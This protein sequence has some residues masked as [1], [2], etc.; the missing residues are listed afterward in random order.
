MSDNKLVKTIMDAALF[1]VVFFA[2]ERLLK[3]AHDENKM[4]KKMLSQLKDCEKKLLQRE[5]ELSQCE[6]ELSQC[7]EKLSQCEKAL[8]T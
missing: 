1:G 4:A 2:V 5:K 3:F 7:E 8:S 6:E